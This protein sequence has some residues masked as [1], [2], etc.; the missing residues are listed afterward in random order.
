M[1][2]ERD[3]PPCESMGRAAYC[4]WDIELIDYHAL[5]YNNQEELGAAWHSIASIQSLSE[6]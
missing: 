6:L 3:A 4:I 5:W 2:Y 1:S